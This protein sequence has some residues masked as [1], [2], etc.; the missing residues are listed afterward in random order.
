MMCFYILLLSYNMYQ[1]ISAQMPPKFFK[2][3]DFFL[4]LPQMLANVEFIPINLIKFKAPPVQFEVSAELGSII[5]PPL[6]C[7]KM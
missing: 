3:S 6:H 7:D 4:D 1:L 5:P 2:V